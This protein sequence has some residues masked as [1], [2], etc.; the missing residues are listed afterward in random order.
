MRIDAST[1]LYGIIGRPVGHSLSPAMHNAA[2][3][4]LGINAVYLAFETD[5]PERAMVAVRTLGIRGLS[6]TV[7][8]K[9]TVMDFLDETDE[10]AR[11]IG[12]VNTVKNLDGRLYGI[13]TD[14]I[15][16]VEAL[17]AET[18]IRGRTAV[19]LGAGGSARAVAFGLA[20]EGARVHIANRT[21]EKARKLA[22]EFGCTFSG[23]RDL[24]QVEG[25]IL[26][27]TT[28]VGMGSLAGISPVP[29]EELDGFSLVMDIVYGREQ[30]R[31][32]KDAESRGCRIIRGTEMLLYQAASQFEFW[33][34]RQ[35][36][37]EVMKKALMDAMSI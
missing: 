34:G 36:P 19:V 11:Q 25:A 9:E 30:T 22:R 35:A 4:H 21:V 14:W 1:K 31:L 16:A 8:N 10:T 28:S 27:N 37:V 24:P 23:L 32:L 33:T 18:G 2:F 15:G 17:K 26:V 29:E 5:S 12:A 6:V 13:N 7:P 20:R 3:E